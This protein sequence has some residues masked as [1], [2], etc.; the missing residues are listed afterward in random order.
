MAVRI[1]RINSQSFPPGSSPA[2]IDAIQQL[3]AAQAESGKSAGS[4]EEVAQGAQTV[5]DAQRVRNDQQDQVLVDHASQINSLRTDVDNQGGQITN[6]VRKDL[7]TLQVM[8]GPLSVNQE[9]RISNV[10]VMGARNTGWEATTG[11]QKKGGMNAD[12]A[13]NASATYSQPEIQAIAGGLVE[14]RQ[15]VAALIAAF[16]SHG[17]I[18]S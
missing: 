9:L 4:A 17:A 3:V 2:F 12:N 13:Y 5:A 10:K 14:V 15:V 7:T 8:A 16:T 18:G 6:A 11:T 1:V